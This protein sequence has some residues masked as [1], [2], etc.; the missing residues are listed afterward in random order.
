MR[1]R[2]YSRMAL[3]NMLVNGKLYT[4]YLITCV[5]T[6]AM[7]FIVVSMAI[8]DLPGGETMRVLMRLGQ[9]LIALFSGVFLYY[10]NSFLIRR[11]K[12]ELA[13]Y[14]ILGL[15]KRH[16]FRIL[17]DETLLTAL[18]GIGGGVLFGAVLDKVMYLV[19]LN[20]MH[21]DVTQA[22][23]LY[24]EA[25]LS[26]A[27][28]FLVIFALIL[29]ANFRQ[30]RKIDPIQLLH[31]EHMGEREP[32]VKWPLVVI[33]VLTLGAGYAI[34]VLV[35]NVL[36]ALLLFFVAVVLDIIGTYCLFTAGSIAVL[37]AMKGSRRYY[38]QPRHFV[39]VSGLLFRMKQ[40]AAG[41]A[42]ICILSTMVLVTLCTTVSRYIG[43]ED[44]ISK[45]Y[46]ADIS[47]GVDAR[48]DEERAALLELVETTVADSGQNVTRLVDYSTLKFAMGMKNG[49]FSTDYRDAAQQNIYQLSVITAEDYSRVTG[50]T[51]SLAPDEVIL[52][53]EGGRIPDTFTLFGETYRVARRLEEQPLFQ[54]SGVMGVVP[55]NIVVDSRG[56][57]E[58]IHAAQQAAYGADASTLFYNIQL[59]T[60]GTDEAKIALRQTLHDEIVRCFRDLRADSG[61]MAMTTQCRAE[62]ARDLYSFYGSFL[63]LGIFMGALFLL[64]TVLIIYY[65][66][67]V[68]GYDDR[69]RF[70][71][72][73]KVGMDKPMIRASIR[74]QVLTMFALPIVTAAIHLAFAFP[75]LTRLLQAL[76]LTDIPLIAVCTVGVLLVFAVIYVLV[77]CITARTYFRIVSGGGTHGA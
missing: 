36:A 57:L 1:K 66:Q 28:V 4:P 49:E 32:K 5:V 2:F 41:L 71:I 20:L 63:F 56:T 22:F 16:I 42:N 74:S 7:Y 38:Y 12:K 27:A 11:R 10:T 76:Y 70:A 55:T 17:L 13:L 53:D 21:F 23:H 60:D 18:I 35:E 67:L 25:L 30:I 54:W 73:Q 24:P 58:A 46:P 77:Y 6:V 19:L 3:T 33:G 39:S 44:L 64:V 8:T 40:N 61:G 26:S 14:N 50:E 62:G 15:E 59:D 34:A 72:M 43:V 51:V 31:S 75:M 52:Y 47:I 29:L 48:N 68:E 37:K 45:E 9:V 69:E 65:K